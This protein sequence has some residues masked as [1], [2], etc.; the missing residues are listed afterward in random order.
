[1]KVST[2]QFKPILFDKEK[3]IDTIRTYIVNDTSDLIIFP[4][5]AT[6]GYYYTSKEELYNYAEPFEGET[7]S[8]FQNLAASLNKIII[9]GFPENADGKFYNS[10]AILFPDDAYST[11]YRKTHLFYKEN[12]I[13]TPGNTGFFNIKYPDFDL[14]LGTMICY[15]WRFPEAARSLALQGADLIV[16]PSNLITKIW[17]TSMPSRAMDNHVYLIVANRIGDEI[18]EESL[19]FNGQS[20]IYDYYGNEIISANKTEE[21]KLTAEINPAEARNKRIN[22]IND[23]FIDRKKQFYIS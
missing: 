6:S 8:E 1:M 7:V 20:V 19:Q 12:Q 5:L 11:V 14:N 13:F 3:N 23:L 10:A 21:I 17:K 16:A 9:F 18:R 22:D 4:E 15:D 2:V